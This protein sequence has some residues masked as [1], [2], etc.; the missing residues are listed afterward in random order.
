MTTDASGTAPS[1]RHLAQFLNEAERNARAQRASADEALNHF[2]ANAADD[3]QLAVDTVALRHSPARNQ[4]YHRGWRLAYLMMTNVG[5]HL[6]AVGDTAAANPPRVFAHMTLARAALEGAA[7]IHFLLHP[8]GTLNE[9]IVR[10]AILLVASAEEELKAVTELSSSSP[11]LYAAALPQAT[12]RHDDI[13][14][15]IDRAGIETQLRRDGRVETLSLR[16]ST[17]EAT[18]S[19]PNITRHLKLLLPTKP[20]AYRVGSGAVHSQPWVLDDDD[21]FDLRSRRLEWRFDATALASS[22]DLAIT[23]SALSLEA[24]ASMLGQDAS[25]LSL[26]ANRRIRRVA[27]MAERAVAL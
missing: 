13:V 5:D 26:E 14:K 15:L 27:T 1:D 11:F 9:R 20:A 4:L 17:E 23:A 21:A 3:C 7:R 24:F 16:S 2:S 8:A 10:S 22:L 18:A 25:S 19:Q 6:C 12:R